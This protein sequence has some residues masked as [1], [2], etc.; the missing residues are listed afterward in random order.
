MVYWWKIP[1]QCSASARGYAVFSKGAGINA[2]IL[3]STYIWDHGSFAFHLYRNAA[4][5]RTEHPNTFVSWLVCV[6]AA[7]AAAA[8]A[9]RKNL[10]PANK[11]RARE[12]RLRNGLADLRVPKKLCNKTKHTCNRRS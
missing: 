2:A 5:A 8:V 4:K 11:L 1:K 9:A 10:P 7:T 12:P 6:L 3:T